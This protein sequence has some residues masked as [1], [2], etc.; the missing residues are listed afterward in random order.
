MNFEELVERKN[1]YKISPWNG[2]M[3][4]WS[5]WNTRCYFSLDQFYCLK[6]IEESKFFNSWKFMRSTSLLS[7]SQ[8]NSKSLA[9][10]GACLTDIDSFTLFWQ[11][12]FQHGNM[13]FAFSCDLNNIGKM[14]DSIRRIFSLFF[15]II[16]EI[17]MFHPTVFRLLSKILLD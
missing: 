5:E 3:K 9:F 6:N 17:P 8:L 4:Y 1:G 2:E 7:G 11:Y 13:V 14:S 16:V 15:A 10:F 12:V